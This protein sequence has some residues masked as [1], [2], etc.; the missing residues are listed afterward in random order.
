MFRSDC[1]DEETR[2]KRCS[3]EF[4][5]CLEKLNNDIYNKVQSDLGAAVENTVAGVRYFRVQHD[6]PRLTEI[7]VKNPLF[8]R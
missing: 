3:E 6:G 4:K 8:Q 1:F 2:L 5:K 7:S